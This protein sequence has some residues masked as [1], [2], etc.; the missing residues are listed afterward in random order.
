MHRELGHQSGPGTPKG[1]SECPL[2]LGPQHKSQPDYKGPRQCECTL[3]TGHANMLQN[4]NHCLPG[5]PNPLYNYMK[6][7]M[8]LS[9]MALVLVS[10]SLQVSHV[11]FIFEK[12]IKEQMINDREPL[13]SCFITTILKFYKM[14]HIAAVYIY[15]LVMKIHF[16]TA[17]CTSLF[18]H[19]REYVIC[20]TKISYLIL[21]SNNL[22]SNLFGTSNS[23]LHKCPEVNKLQN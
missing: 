20:C 9:G 23:Y 18:H 15:I 13:M 22:I 6:N 10:S 17:V 7:I 4:R 19:I 8:S 5:V 2:S 11:M 14:Q 16:T 3:N 12:I 1:N 21:S